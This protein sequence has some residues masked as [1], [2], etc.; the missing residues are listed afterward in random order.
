MKSLVRDTTSQNTRFQKITINGFKLKIS[1]ISYYS[2]II[3][4]IV[5]NLRYNLIQL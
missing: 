4:L 5:D 3:N 2:N 1:Q